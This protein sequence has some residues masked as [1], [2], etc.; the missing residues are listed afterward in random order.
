M[1]NYQNYT[2]GTFYSPCYFVNL[3]MPR[4]GGPENVANYGVWSPLILNLTHPRTRDRN[5]L[6]AYITTL[7]PFDLTRKSCTPPCPW[8]LYLAF[9]AKVRGFWD[10][11]LLLDTKSI[12]SKKSLFEISF[13]CEIPFTSASICTKNELLTLWID[14]DMKVWSMAPS[15]NPL[16]LPICT[17]LGTFL[18]PSTP[19]YAILS[20]SALHDQL[21]ELHSRNIL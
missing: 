13:L 6:R 9:N 15:A 18:W 16:K 11:T 7:H 3:L 21:S 19:P 10:F 17:T 14:K 1:T 20:A 12:P 4:G 5:Y 2:V 8:R